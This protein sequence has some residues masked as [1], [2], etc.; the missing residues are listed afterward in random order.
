[1]KHLYLLMSWPEDM[2]MLWIRFLSF[3]SVFCSLNFRCSMIAHIY[4]SGGGIKFS[5]FA[6][7]HKLLTG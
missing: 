1:M 3:V 2:G 4:K 5:E 7:F 6:C